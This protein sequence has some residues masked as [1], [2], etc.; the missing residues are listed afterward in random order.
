[1]MKMALSPAAFGLLRALA[2]RAEIPRDRILLTSWRSVDWQSLTFVGER[3]HISL[4][5]SGPD[6]AEAVAR[7][8]SGLDDAEFAIPGH[9]VADITVVGGP[10][11]A[12]D[13]S[14]TLNIEALTIA[15]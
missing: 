9:I 5:V 11:R 10:D 3:H 4:G 1:M 15:E 2:A 12:S 6:S 8:T 13:D 7:L 14:T